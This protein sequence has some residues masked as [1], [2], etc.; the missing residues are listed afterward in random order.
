M[1]WTVPEV[2]IRQLRDHLSRY[3]NQVRGGAELTITDHG[4]AVARIVPVDQP[5][6][7]DQLIEE[8]QVTP[9]SQTD[10]TRPRRRIRA[11]GA[12]SPLVP[13]QRR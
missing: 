13:D 1:G 3:L 7:L 4:R 2:G 8:G 6:L 12:V 11:S 10:R 9:A 5:R